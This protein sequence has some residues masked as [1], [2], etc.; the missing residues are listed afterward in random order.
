[1]LVWLVFSHTNNTGF[2]VMGVQRMARVTKPVEERRQ[3]IIDTARLMFMENGFENTQMADISKK[4]NVAA[5]TLYHYFKSKTELLYA[6]IDELTDENTRQKHQLMNET[7][8]SA[9]D[10]LEFVFTMFENGELQGDLSSSFL[11]DP[12]IVQYYFAR[13]SSSFLPVLISLIKQGNEDG[14]WSCEYPSETALFILNGMAGVMSNEQTRK[15][16]PDE[17]SKRLNAYIHFILRVLG[18]DNNRQR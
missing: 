17:K 6:V 3:E 5:G 16:N 12:A 8:G 14:S 11:S 4:M 10:R 13:I 7:K 9:F 1:M 18:T 2:R 15:D